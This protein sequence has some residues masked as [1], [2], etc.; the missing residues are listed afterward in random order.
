MSDPRIEIFV[1]AGHGEYRIQQST[2]NE[3]AIS[4]TLGTVNT[5]IANR[6]LVLASS[7]PD[8]G[9]I[10]DAIEIIDAYT[11]RVPEHNRVN[12]D[13]AFISA[14]GDILPPRPEDGFEYRT[15]YDGGA[16]LPHTAAAITLSQIETNGDEIPLS[17]PA[18]YTYTPA[19]GAITLT[20]LN[21]VRIV[22]RGIS[23]GAWSVAIVVSRIVG[24]YALPI[25]SRAPDSRDPVQWDHLFEG[26]V[27]GF[28]YAED[29]QP[30]VDLARNEEDELPIGPQ[31][32]SVV[33]KIAE[34]VTKYDPLYLNSAGEA[35]RM[36]AQMA[37]N[38]V[39]PAFCIG[40]ASRTAVAGETIRS[41]YKGEVVDP[42]WNWDV[43]TEYALWVGD[44]GGLSVS[45]PASVGRALQVALIIS[46][47]K[48]MIDTARIDIQL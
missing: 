10:G 38:L 17:E 3:R 43:A 45:P 20:T 7:T 32:L 11:V 1:D 12:G 25:A 29:G 22:A 48:I 9:I 2:T 30:L 37:E 26:Y 36:T 5:S 28:V 21:D 23:S 40:I 41:L 19:T 33:I 39:K 4:E 13:Q 8:G 15:H 27:L 31:P 6:L 24:L 46:A 35:I 34:D 44:S 18:D 42:A 14:G 16:V 47:N